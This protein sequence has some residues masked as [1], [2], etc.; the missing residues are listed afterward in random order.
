MPKGPIAS[1]AETAMRTAR[2]AASRWR[3]RASDKGA[4]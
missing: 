1:L 4:A 3:Q 2:D